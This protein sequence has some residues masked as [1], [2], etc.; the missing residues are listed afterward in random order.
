MKT[1][2]KLRS[3]DT[4]TIEPSATRQS[5]SLR[6]K[7]VIGISHGVLVANADWQAIAE[8]GSAVAAANLATLAATGKAAQ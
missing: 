3:G 4:L 8:A 5:V 6:I 1:S 7:S 2:L